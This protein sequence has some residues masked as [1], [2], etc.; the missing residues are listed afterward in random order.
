MDVD[1]EVRYERFP[2]DTLY[3]AAFDGRYCDLA[4]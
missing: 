1:V 2:M 3:C 4:L